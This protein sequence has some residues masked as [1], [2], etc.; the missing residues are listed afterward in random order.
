MQFWFF[1][2][3]LFS[4][5]K[6]RTKFLKHFR[7]VLCP[8]R[9]SCNTS[10]VSLLKFRCISPIK[11]LL[12]KF[13]LH[14]VAPYPKVSK[15][16]TVGNSHQSAILITAFSRKW[17][18]QCDLV[19][20]GLKRQPRRHTRIPKRNNITGYQQ[21]ACFFEAFS[22]RLHFILQISAN[23]RTLS[24]ASCLS[25]IWIFRGDKWMAYNGQ[26]QL[27]TSLIFLKNAV[28]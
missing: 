9:T 7:Y 2:L 11:T 15:F 16:P 1:V 26:H 5:F 23:Y 4:P 25:V 28:L 13:Q 18:D 12:Q 8:L 10:S 21:P 22:F 6:S 19:C 24:K 3:R 17:N 20:T 14:Q 27:Q